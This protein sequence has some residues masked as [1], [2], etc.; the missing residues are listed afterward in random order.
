MKFERGTEVEH[1]RNP[2]WRA[3]IVRDLQPRKPVNGFVLLNHEG[4]EA[5]MLKSLLKK[6]N[7]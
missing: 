3:V 1:K 2:A 5:R 7:R 6:V 4:R